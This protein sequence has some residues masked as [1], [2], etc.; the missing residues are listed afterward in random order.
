MS[1]DVKQIFD[2][3]RE[4]IQSREAAQNRNPLLEPVVETTLELLNHAQE[5]AS[6]SDIIRGKDDKFIRAIY[7]DGE[8]IIPD[9]VSIN[10]ATWKKD[11]IEIEVNH[12]KAPGKMNLGRFDV[13]ADTFDRDISRFAAKLSEIIL[14]S[15]P[16]GPA[17]ADIGSP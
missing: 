8:N 1:I 4:D 15:A 5:A 7:D 11:A 6:I 13:S 2:A 16:Q 17:P 12:W 3:V 14:T 9:F 10:F